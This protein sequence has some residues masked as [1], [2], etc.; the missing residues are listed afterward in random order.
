L[1]VLGAFET[2]GNS[3]G[4]AIRKFIYKLPTKNY[5]KI[6]SPLLASSL[7]LNLSTIKATRRRLGISNDFNIQLFSTKTY[8]KGCS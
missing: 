1:P 7:V 5:T 6:L 4:G 8:Y 3:L 2:W